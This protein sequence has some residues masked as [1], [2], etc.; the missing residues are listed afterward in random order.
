MVVLFYKENNCVQSQCSKQR[1]GFLYLEPFNKDSN[2]TLIISCLNLVY[3]VGSQK[4][5][6]VKNIVDPCSVGA[7]N[8]FLSDLLVND[9]IH[10]NP[11]IPLATVN[12]SL[13]TLH[14]SGRAI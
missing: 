1:R 9:D 4:Q 8:R 6:P 2:I 11:P 14:S 12:Q 3:T 10:I 7:A 13:Q 5:T